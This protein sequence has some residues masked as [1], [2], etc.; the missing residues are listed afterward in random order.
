M[1][2]CDNR[3]P[4]FRQIEEIRGKCLACRVCED[5]NTLQLGGGGVVHADAA[6]DPELVYRLTESSNPAPPCGVTALPPDVEDGLRGLL[7]AFFGLDDVT[8]L[9]IAHLARGGN[10]A[11]FDGSLRDLLGRL[12]KAVGK[13]PKVAKAFAWARFRAAVRAFGPFAAIAGGLIGKGKGGA[14]KGG[15]GRGRYQCE[16]DFGE[17]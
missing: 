11:N 8:Q 17:G 3:C 14:V 12:Q 2:N 13:K 16:L 5:G 10:L 4:V 15:R 6:A 1:A 7:A 9:L